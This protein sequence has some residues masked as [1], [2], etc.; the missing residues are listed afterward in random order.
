ML[1]LRDRLGMRN[2]QWEAETDMTAGKGSMPVRPT[3]FRII[4]FSKY[5]QEAAVSVLCE[6]EWTWERLCMYDAA[7]GYDRGI[8][9]A[10]K[11]MLTACA[12]QHDPFDYQLPYHTVILRKNVF[13]P[14][15]TRNK[16]PCHRQSCRNATTVS[17]LRFK[18]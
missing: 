10:N 9:A 15:G 14:A 5:F 8:S 13:G 12:V 18:G 17:S 1:T 4:G 16:S 2:R 3:S 6:Q 11:T 7:I